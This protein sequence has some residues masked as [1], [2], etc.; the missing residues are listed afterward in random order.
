MSALRGAGREPLVKKLVDD[1]LNGYAV[2]LISALH[3]PFRSLA[4]EKEATVALKIF[5]E[6]VRGYRQS[7]APD[8]RMRRGRGCMSLYPEYAG[9]ALLEEFTCQISGPRAKLLAAAIHQ[10]EKLSR[11]AIVLLGSGRPTL[12]DRVLRLFHL[13]PEF[14][15]ERRGGKAAKQSALPLAVDSGAYMRRNILENESS[16]FATW[17]VEERSFG[18][19]PWVAPQGPVIVDS[20]KVCSN[21]L[22]PKVQH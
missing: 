21:P 20:E 9:K 4:A 22:V 5:A 16:G 13:T 1:I 7:I 8:Q 10:S 11:D 17:S 19:T 14:D 2:T 15:S 6:A 18:A 3:D 12:E